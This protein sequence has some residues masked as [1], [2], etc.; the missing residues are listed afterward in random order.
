MATYYMSD[1]HEFVSQNR[2]P[3]PKKHKQN[4]KTQP[5]QR[6]LSTETYPHEALTWMFNQLGKRVVTMAIGEPQAITIFIIQQGTS[7]HDF[8]LVKTPG[9]DEHISSSDT[10]RLTPTTRRTI[11]LS[12]G[13]LLEKYMALVNGIK[14]I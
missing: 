1:S 14:P 12:I 6:V 8:H 7:V 10:F 13:G 4:N 3:P 9:K 5:T 2:D 11:L